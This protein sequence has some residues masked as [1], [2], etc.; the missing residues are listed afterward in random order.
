MFVCLFVC[1]SACLPVCLSI[2]LIVWLV[3]CLFFC[4]SCFYFRNEN[5]LFWMY[6]TLRL[7]P[8]ENYRQV[9]G[10][11]IYSWKQ[12]KQEKRANRLGKCRLNGST[13]NVPSSLHPPIPLN[14]RGVGTR[15]A[16]FYLT[17]FFDITLSSLRV[18]LKRARDRSTG[19]SS[20]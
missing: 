16:T 13:I 17:P 1:L 6:F 7:L 14:R 3:G 9:I 19:E 4:C 11:G 12:G 8:N 10:N 2:C 15:W 20:F 18:I 5:K